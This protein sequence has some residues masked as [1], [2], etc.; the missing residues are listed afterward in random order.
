MYRRD[1]HLEPV[2]MI[3]Q[4]REGD[5]NVRVGVNCPYY[6]QIFDHDRDLLFQ[7]QVA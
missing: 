3:Q 7:L 6:V 5:R 2:A 1:S 4:Y